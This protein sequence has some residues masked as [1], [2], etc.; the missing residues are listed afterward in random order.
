MFT[1]PGVVGVFA[2]TVVPL[3]VAVTGL[4]RGMFA[5]VVLVGFVPTVFVPAVVLFVP[6]PSIVCCPVGCNP[7]PLPLKV[8]GF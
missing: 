2:G 3:V 6:V 7:G 5:G 1:G 8:A 4:T